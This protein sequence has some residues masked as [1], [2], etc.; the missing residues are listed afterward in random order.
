MRTSNPGSRGHT[1]VLFPVSGSIAYKSPDS[2]TN[3]THLS[4]EY[5]HTEDEGKDMLLFARK[6][7]IGLLAINQAYYKGFAYDKKGTVNFSEKGARFTSLPNDE[8][9]M[10]PSQPDSSVELTS[11]VG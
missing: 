10:H 5:R 9:Q 3:A 11:P 7:R 2:S 1:L 8:A 6:V 4:S